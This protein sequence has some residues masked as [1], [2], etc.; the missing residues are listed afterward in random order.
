MSYGDPYCLHR[1]I[2]PWSYVNCLFG[3]NSGSPFLPEHTVY[4]SVISPGYLD[5]FFSTQTEPRMNMFSGLSAELLMLFSNCWQQGLRQNT[6][7]Q[8]T[9][10][11][12]GNLY[13][14]KQ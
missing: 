14:L 2:F 11:V 10:M 5:H 13:L 3:D 1:L 4:K 8:E 7:G 12:L 6:Q 9:S